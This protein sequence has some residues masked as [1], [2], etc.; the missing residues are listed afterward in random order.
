MVNKHSDVIIIGGGVIGSSIAYFLAALDA[1]DGSILV[2]EKDLTY[3]Q[4]STTLSVGGIRQQ[5]STP[6]NIEISKF[7]ASFFKSIKKLLAVD[8]YQPEISFHEAGYLFLAS[9]QGLPILM[10]NYELQQSHGV[11]I[12]LMTPADLTQYFNWLN[13]S[14]L[15]A[16]ALG[17]KNEGWIDPYSL[18]MAFM[19]K[20]R[21]LGV[22]YFEDKV[23]NVIRNGNRIT[24]I[25]LMNGGEVT[26]K[27]VVN[28]AGP[29]AAEVAEMAGID[30]LPVCPRKR[31]VY[32]F[33]CKNKIH[34]CPLVID[35][36]GVYFRPE[37][38][39]Y[40]CGVSPLEDKDPDCLDFNMDYRLFEE[41]I[42]PALAH[43]VPSF[44]AIKRSHSWA[45][46]YAYNIKDQ[47]AIVGSHPEVSNFYFANG[48]SGHGLQQAPAVGRAISELI[49]FG[50]Y[51]TLD[52][53]KF[54]FER[55]A[56]G[57]LVKEI[58]VV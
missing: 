14:D 19:R 43:R 11:D 44:E 36:C 57:E 10:K 37:G 30:D 45:G 1:F 35:P 34:N 13:I 16:G 23:I 26:C 3:T 21:S 51:Q 55:F 49:T 52:L 33:Q 48:F 28:A 4:C 38:E 6:E 22:K 56:N 17:L 40:L 2:V 47:N 46:H 20:A 27:Y 32:S 29:L 9:E 53:S 7:A 42:W 50:C 41:T 54:A 58:N 31:F 18:L 24:A 12:R 39:K 8:D 5:F 25:C 15:T